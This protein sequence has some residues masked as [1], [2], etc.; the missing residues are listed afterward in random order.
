MR[1]IVVLF[2]SCGVLLCTAF[3]LCDG[4][5]RIKSVLLVEGGGGLAGKF[6]VEVSEIDGIEFVSVFLTDWFGH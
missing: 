3:N 2:S 1:R 6:C 4:Y 5:L